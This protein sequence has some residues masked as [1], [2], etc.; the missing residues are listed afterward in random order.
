MANQPRDVVERFHSEKRREE[1]EKE[2]QKTLMQSLY[3]Q[4]K[5]WYHL[6][7]L[8]LCLYEEAPL[9]RKQKGTW[10]EGKETHFMQ[11]LPSQGRAW[12]VMGCLI[13]HLCAVYHVM[14]IYCM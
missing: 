6:A 14:F 7:G 4:R 10:G 13:L 3:N 9:W 2:K 11:C 1:H 8:I 12:S 5:A